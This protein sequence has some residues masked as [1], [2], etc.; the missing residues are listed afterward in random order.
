MLALVASPAAAAD[1]GE[2]VRV[3]APASLQASSYRYFEPRGDAQSPGA[4]WNPCRTITYGI[5]FRAAKKHG[6]NPVWERKRWKSVVAELAAASGLRFR[7]V[8]QITTRPQGP[9]PSRVSG[10]DI[11]LSYGTQ[12]S[13]G[14][15]LKGSIAGVAGVQWHRSG[16]AGRKQITEGYVVIDAA[17]VVRRISGWNAPFDPRPATKRSPDV[18]RSLY[19]HEFGHALGM[20]HV[21]DKAQIMYPTLSASRPDVLGDGDVIGL[22]KLGRQPC[23]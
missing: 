5:D 16:L 17:E 23:F 13:Y 12:K 6:L 14:K 4:Y 2:P 7:Y 22:R 19:M 11:R 15:V 3:A 18:M 8:G 9:R 20:E 21:R 10:V 1:V